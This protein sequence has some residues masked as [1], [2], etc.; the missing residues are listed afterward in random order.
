VYTIHIR[1][2]AMPELIDAWT[3]GRGNDCAGFV[4]G[5]RPLMRRLEE[6]PLGV[7]ESRGSARRRVAF[8]NGVAA[9]FRVYP[10]LRLVRV[11]RA[12][13]FRHRV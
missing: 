6:D 10:R 12:W 8:G 13:S 9:A 11:L 3:A 1:E 4:A 7:G 2:G 5:M